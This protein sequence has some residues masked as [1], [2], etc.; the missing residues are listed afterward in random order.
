[1]SDE[2]VVSVCCI[3]YN[4][5]DYIE[6]CIESI[7]SQKF[8]YKIEIIVGDDCSTDG[9]E[10][11]L[12]EL[13]KL[14]SD[15]LTIVSNKRNLGANGN[16]LSVFERAKGEYIAFCEGDDYW[17]DDHKLAKQ[18]EALQTHPEVNFCFHQAYMEV[19]KNRT[20]YFDYGDS[21]KLFNPDDVLRVVGQFAPT[22]SY[23]FR[24]KAIDNLPIWFEDC[25][26]GDLFLELYTMSNGGL[27]I[28]DAMS[29]YRVNAVGS[30][31]ETIRNDINKFINRHL[32]IAQ[33][34]ELARK[35]FPN[36]STEFAIK[37]ANVYLNMCTRFILEERHDL[38]VFYLEKANAVNTNRTTKHKVYNFLK[39]HPR[40][41]YY[42]HYF[43]SFLK[44]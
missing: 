1:M 10:K 11:K 24:R 18:Y 40:L 12:Y 2:V 5:V 15:V 4:Q 43:N 6:K 33:H 20:K 29:V 13:A 25:C 19:E 35:D 30:W 27:Y 41:I 26:I 8:P 44:K 32:N 42:I 22:A 7:V 3:T 17:V 31:S 36:Y 21:S 28:P 37:I 38:F 16:I 9:T 14:H 39:I 34:L 23:F